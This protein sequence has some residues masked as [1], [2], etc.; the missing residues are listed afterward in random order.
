MSG[1]LEPVPF[2][3]VTWC[4]TQTTILGQE[5]PRR[6]LTYPLSIHK[7]FVDDSASMSSSCPSDCYFRLLQQAADKPRGGRV[8]GQAAVQVASLATTPK[9]THGQVAVIESPGGNSAQGQN[10]S[11]CSFAAGSALAN[12]SSSLHLR[13]FKV[14]SSSAL[15]VLGLNPRVTVPSPLSRGQSEGHKQ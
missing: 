4:G 3:A 11:F 8:K 14:T 12:M 7:Q 15:H 10:I 6:T 2:C 9:P 13:L 5:Q 1:A